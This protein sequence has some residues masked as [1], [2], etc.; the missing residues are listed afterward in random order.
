MSWQLWS[1]HLSHSRTDLK[2][3]PVAGTDWEIGLLLGL[4]LCYKQFPGLSVSAVSFDSI[5]ISEKFL[6]FFFKSWHR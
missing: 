2:I 1:V 4:K 5:S 6:M 3:L